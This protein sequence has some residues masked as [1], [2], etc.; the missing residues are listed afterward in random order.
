MNVEVLTTA[1]W[2]LKYNIFQYVNSICY[3]YTVHRLFPG[4]FL[5]IKGSHRNVFQ[6]G[7]FTRV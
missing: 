7:K 6:T 1:V 4:C 3:V 2:P 5:S